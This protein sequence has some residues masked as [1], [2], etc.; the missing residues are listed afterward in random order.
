[1]RSRIDL[2]RL[3]ARS[4]A[5]RYSLASDLADGRY[6]LDPDRAIAIEDRSH[7]RELHRYGTL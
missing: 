3:S 6:D 5:E 1:L 7:L 2:S 4:H